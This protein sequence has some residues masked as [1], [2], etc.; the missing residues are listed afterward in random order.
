MGFCMLYRKKGQ[1][2][3]VRDPD[4]R[5]YS[6]RFDG[7]NGQRLLFTI[8]GEL[9]QIPLKGEHYIDSREVAMIMP[10][11]Y[12]GSLRLG[13]DAPGMWDIVREEVPFKN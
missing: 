13:I 3:K 5:I 9:H 11:S 4:K 10:I 7:F 6:I 8:D 1:S 12:D 2:I